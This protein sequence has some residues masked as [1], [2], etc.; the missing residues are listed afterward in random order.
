MKIRVALIGNMNNN[1]FTLTRYLR[2]RGV[3]AELLLFNNEHEHFHPKCDTYDTGY[4][5]FVRQLS[6]GDVM[7]FTVTLSQQIRKDL[8]AYDVLIGCGLSPAYCAKAK[9]SLDIFVP[10]GDDI[11]TDTLYRWV[12]PHRI[13]RL[14][15]AVS[16]QRRAIGKAKVFH[17]GLTNGL[18]EEQ[19]KKFGGNSKR[20]L[21]NLPMVYAPIYTRDQLSQMITRTHWGHEFA[22]IREEADLMVMAHMRHS[23]GEATDP[24]AKG[25]DI[26]LRGWKLFCDQKPNLSAR[27]VF[28]EYGQ[29]IDKTRSLISELGLHA[30]VA[31]L[32]KMYRKD[33]MVG[34]HMAD[35]VC[36]EF[37]NSWISSGVLYEGLVAGKPILAWRDD[38]LYTDDYPTLYP[39]LKA[40]TPQSIAERLSEYM[41]NPIKYKQMGDKGQHWYSM[42][43]VE[44]TLKKYVKYIQQRAVELGKT[45]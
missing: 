29:D 28:M 35:I 18:Y 14:W 10:Y 22:K 11:W 42:E 4:M 2:D 12:S 25:V 8:S 9:I 39:I 21:E 27:L 5:D 13:P 45:L 44:P 6:W 24:N 3:D 26:L 41:Q 32:P 7:G 36:G 34:L 37:L 20:W 23:W 19:Y 43:V 17:M 38:S 16:N 30:R 15:I 40:Q 1:H 31:W 33:I